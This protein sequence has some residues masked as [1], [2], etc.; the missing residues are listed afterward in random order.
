MAQFGAIQDEG[1][2]RRRWI[3]DPSEPGCYI[4]RS[5]LTYPH[6][7]EKFTNL[8]TKH[9]HPEDDFDEHV[10]DAMV[11][12]EE[13]KVIA[14]D[15]RQWRN[16]DI[17]SPL[18]NVSAHTGP[19]MIIIDVMFRARLGG[20]ITAELMANVPAASAVVQA[21]YT[22]DFDLK[23]LRCVFVNCIVNKNT[24][25]FIMDHIYKPEIFAEFPDLDFVPVAWDYGTPEYDGLLG[26]RIGRV[27]AYLILEA[28][29]RGA[30]RIS[31]ITTYM[32]EGLSATHLRFDIEA[33]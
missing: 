8:T 17:Y 10:L 26:T 9:V 7:L 29:E 30:R 22:R 3:A 19:G 5:T 18:L 2:Q 27:V 16:F 25:G 6:L 20:P 4:E 12:P 28:F 14:T 24:I 15:R 33:I 31:R 13:S 23:D 32:S 21:L 11:E 1:A